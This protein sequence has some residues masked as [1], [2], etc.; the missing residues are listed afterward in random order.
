MSI[1]MPSSFSDRTNI[2]FNI[3]LFYIIVEIFQHKYIL[4][5]ILII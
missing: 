4:T 5:C 1:R 3:F 2:V